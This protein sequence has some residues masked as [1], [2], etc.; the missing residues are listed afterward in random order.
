MTGRRGAGAVAAARRR[1]TP[2]GG[3]TTGL[4]VFGAAT[5]PYPDRSETDPQAY[6]SHNA[7][8]GTMGCH[9]TYSS[10]NL[11]ATWAAT[12]AA[13]YG[14]WQHRWSW[15]SFKQD[16][17]STAAGS[18]YSAIRSWVESIPVTGYKRL[19]TCQHEADVGSKIPNNGSYAQ[20]KQVFYEAGRAVQDAGHPDVLYGLVFGSR[21]SSSKAATIMQATSVTTAALQSVVDFVGWDPYNGASHDGDYSSDRQGSAGVDY[22]LNPLLAWNEQWFPDARFAIGE[23]GYRPNAADLTMRPAYVR[24]FADRCL[25]E[26]ALACCYFDTA[27]VV[28]KQNYMRIYASPRSDAA[29]ASLS[30]HADAPSIAAWS[31]YY[32][33][34][35]A[36]SS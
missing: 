22:Y 20:F 36:W 28:G 11:P 25:A 15:H 34:Y 19:I 29:D 30:W 10:G 18:Q 2:G 8:L 1:T 21:F 7:D 4:T 27:V 23:F 31:S 16:V 12:S 17:A 14:D 26:N 5:N 32:A 24:A 35:P 33:A 3:G 9:R 13:L 6:A